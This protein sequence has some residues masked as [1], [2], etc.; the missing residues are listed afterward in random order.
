ML[1]SPKEKQKEIDNNDKGNQKKVIL[2]IMHKFMIMQKEEN[3]YI[4]CDYSNQ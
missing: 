1:I 2:Y 4:H 3:Y